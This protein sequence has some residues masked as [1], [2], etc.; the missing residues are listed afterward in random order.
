[1]TEPWGISGPAFAGLYLGLLLLPVLVAGGLFLRRYLRRA[2]PDRALDFPQVALLAGGRNRLAEAAVADLLER[3]HLRVDGR[4]TLRRTPS[5][6]SEALGREVA[7]QVSP[8]AT[9]YVIR[10][11]LMREKPVS[12][13][14]VDELTTR[15]LLL[16]VRFLKFL[17]AG[18]ASAYL[19]LLV[20]GVVRLHEGLVLQRPVGFLEGEVALAVFALVGTAGG[21][22]ATYGRPVLRTLA[23]RRALVAQR[24]ERGGLPG[25][26]GA[27]ALGGLAAHPDPGVRIALMWNGMPPRPATRASGSAGGFFIGGGMSGGGG[28]ASCGGGS[29]CGGGGGGGGGCGCGG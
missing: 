5:Q 21:L 28:G 27:V 18:T 8:H 23:G 10:R 11:F 16:D 9:M 13:P 25:A 1:M 7:G 3:E 4:G 24:Y 29:S 6:P 2:E 26:A 14:V 15:G 12:Q 20:L 19:T 17:G 22:V